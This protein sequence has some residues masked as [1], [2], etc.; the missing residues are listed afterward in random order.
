VAESP[1]VNTSPLIYL[2]RIGRLDL[3]RLLSPRIVVPEAV[4]KE[5]RAYQ[6]GDPAVRA[7]DRGGWLE[8]QPDAPISPT[9]WAWDLGLGESAVLAWGQANP[10]TEVIIDDLAA[11]RCASSLSIPVRGTLGIVLIAKTRGLIPLARPIV[12]ELVRVGLYLSS[13]T[14]NDALHRVGE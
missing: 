9:I 13:K 12:E 14:V 8:I 10:G 3:L 11:R 4:A 6:G 1:A 2:G 5:I 7:L